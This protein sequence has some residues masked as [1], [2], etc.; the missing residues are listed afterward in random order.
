MNDATTDLD[1]TDEEIVTHDVADETL[2]AAA[3]SGVHRPPSTLD[4]ANVLFC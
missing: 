2:E 3:G 1:L 4:W